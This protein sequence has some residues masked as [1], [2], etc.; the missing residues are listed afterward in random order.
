MEASRLAIARKEK[1]KTLKEVAE[2]LGVSASTLCEVEKGMRIPSDDLKKKLAKYYKLPAGEL[3]EAMDRDRDKITIYHLRLR[4]PKTFVE[5]IRELAA[6]QGV[7]ATDIVIEA[8]TRFIEGGGKPAA[9]AKAKEE[10]S[11]AMD[12]DDILPISDMA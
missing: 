5:S 2:K 1:G 9:V 7:Q 8:L 10:Q 12:D 11:A 3:F 4:V 6:S